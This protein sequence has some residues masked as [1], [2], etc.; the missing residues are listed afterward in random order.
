MLERLDPDDQ[1][2]LRPYRD[3]LDDHWAL[4][5]AMP[6]MNADERAAA[7]RFLGKMRR[8]SGEPGLARETA[9]APTPRGAALLGTLRQVDAGITP[10]GEHGALLPATRDEFAEIVDSRPLVRVPATYVQDDS[11]N[12]VLPG[13]DQATRLFSKSTFG[14]GALLLVEQSDA[15]GFS[16]HDPT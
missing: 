13:I 2:L 6:E 7:T 3:L 12:H 8:G 5:D 4:S 10:A 14:N 9:L 15:D 1:R 16:P 11:E